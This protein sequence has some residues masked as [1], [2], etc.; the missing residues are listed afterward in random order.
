MK[1]HQDEAKLQGMFD[2]YHYYYYYDYYDDYDDDE[3]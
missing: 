3:S 1:I 2:D